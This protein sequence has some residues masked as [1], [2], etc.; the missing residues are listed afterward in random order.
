MNAIL[1]F[2][3][4]STLGAVVGL[5]LFLG[6]MGACGGTIAIGKDAPE[7][8]AKEACGPTIMLAVACADGSSPFTGRCL[9][10]KSD[11]TCAWEKHECPTPPVIECS[12]DKCSTGTPPGI[13]CADGSINAS[14]GRCVQSA[15]G[16]CEWEMKGCDAPPTGICT[17]A[18]CGPAHKQALITCTDGSKGGNTGICKPGASGK[19]EWWFR[20]CPPCTP[21]DCGGPRPRSVTCSN[22]STVTSVCKQSVVGSTASCAWDTPVCPSPQVC[23]GLADTKCAPGFYCDGFPASDPCGGGDSTGTCRA[24]PKICITLLAPVCACDHKIYGNVCDAN[25]H[26]VAVLKPAPGTTCP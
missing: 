21:S 6:A 11:K 10:N 23:G 8:C 25:S 24:I 20:D 3:L 26:G 14:T 17:I 15:A 18:D 9:R 1:R 12:K 13:P 4:L 5:P 7:E 22:G 2:Q 19:C 16:V